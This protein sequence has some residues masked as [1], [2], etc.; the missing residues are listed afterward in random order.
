MIY[1]YLVL[2]GLIICIMLNRFYSYSPLT[3]SLLSYQNCHFGVQTIEYLDH[4]ISGQGVQA[5]PGRL[6]AKHD[7][8]APCSLTVLRAFLGLMGFYRRFVQ[9]YATIASPLTDFLKL[10]T[11]SWPEGA[12]KA[13]VQLKSAMQCLPI[14]ALPDFSMPFDVTTD[15]SSIAIG[16]VLSQGGHPITFFCKKMCPYMDASSAYVRE[17]YAITESDKENVVADA[18]S[19]IPDVSQ[20]ALFTSIS[21]QLCQY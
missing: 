21:S 9:N 8:P 2:P 18:L 16:T 1:L 17:L 5:D 6:Q 15:A 7:W 13:F 3:T 12:A 20:E 10:T 14:L 19:R 11:F 4:I